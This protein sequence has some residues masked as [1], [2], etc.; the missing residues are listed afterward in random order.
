[1]AQTAHAMAHFFAKHL[2]IALEWERDSNYLVIVSAPNE[3]LLLGLETTCWGLSLEHYLVREPDLDN[4]A[5]AIALAPGDAARRMCSQLPL[6]L[7][8]RPMVPL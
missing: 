2:Q 5:T 6:A 1:M 4:E 8:E 3:G 7:K